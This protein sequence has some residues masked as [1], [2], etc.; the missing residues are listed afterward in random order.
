LTDLRKLV[1][2][3]PGVNNAWIEPVESTQPAVFYDPSDHSLSLEAATHRRPVPLRGMY[4]VLIEADGS[5]SANDVKGDVS[6]RLHAHRNLCDD[7]E[8]PTILPQQP[9]SVTAT[10]E[11]RSVEDPDRLLACI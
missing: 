4:R 9:L 8:P 7:F 6:R 10:I 3:V 11:V 1:I 2:D 5:R